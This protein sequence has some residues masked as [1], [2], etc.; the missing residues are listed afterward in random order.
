M[1]G[2]PLYLQ[3]PLYEIDNKEALRVNV[4]FGFIQRLA[5]KHWGDW[6]IQIKLSNQRQTTTTDM[7]FDLDIFFN[8]NLL[9][10]YVPDIVLGTRKL[11]ANTTGLVFVLRAQCNK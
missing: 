7:L 3:G 11:M 9:S 4:N 2:L 8:T 1:E 6:Q 5:C 10:F